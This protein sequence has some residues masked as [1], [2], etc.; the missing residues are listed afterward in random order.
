LTGLVG[1]SRFK[2]VILA[3]RHARLASIVLALATVA[4][5]GGNVTAASVTSCGGVAN[6]VTTHLAATP[7]ITKVEVV[8][9]CSSLIVRTSL[10]DTEF[11]SA[12]DLCD[13]AAEVAYTGDTKSVTVLGQSGKELAIGLSTAPCVGEP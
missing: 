13:K 10:A 2:L 7:Q 12:T 3:S 8:G 6:A 1:G 4:A 11:S 5:C 9:R